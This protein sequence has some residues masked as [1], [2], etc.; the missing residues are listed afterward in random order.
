M[1]GQVYEVRSAGI[2]KM[3]GEFK[4]SLPSEAAG[5]RYVINRDRIMRGRIRYVTNL[6]RRMKGQVEDM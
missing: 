4:M 6:D 5:L 2:A 1:R 3:G